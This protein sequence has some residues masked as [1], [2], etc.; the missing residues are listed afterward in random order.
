MA[1]HQ[2]GHANSINGFEQ[3]GGTYLKQ[4][5][6]HPCRRDADLTAYAGTRWQPRSVAFDPVV[7]GKEAQGETLQQVFHREGHV[8][9]RK[10]MSK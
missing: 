3:T 6:K 9:S 7:S 8:W 5:K 1:R 2:L 10:V 4:C